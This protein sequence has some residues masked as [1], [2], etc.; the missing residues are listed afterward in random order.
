MS[1]INQQKPNI[2]HQTA[3]AINYIFKRFKGI[4]PALKYSADSQVGIDSIRAEYTYTLMRHQI[5]SLD[6]INKALDAISDSG[7]R[8]L[9]SPGEFIQFCKLKPE[10]IGAPSCE[11]AYDDACKWAYDYHE[12]LYKF[13]HEAVKLAAHRTKSWP[14]KNQPRSKSYP[15][16]EENYL[17]ACNDIGLSKNTNQI[18]QQKKKEFTVAQKHWIAVYKKCLEKNL[19]IEDETPDLATAELAKELYSEW[20]SSKKG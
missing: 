15:L 4:L 3:K 18:E 10:D 7:A 1:I 17:M 9:P 8:F 16:F 6:V 14:L 12:G 11:E 20:F 5:Y 19:N 13:I 2:D